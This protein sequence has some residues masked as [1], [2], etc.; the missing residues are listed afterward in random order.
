MFFIIT[1][2]N[3][4]ITFSIQIKMDTAETSCHCTEAK[5]HWCFSLCLRR[6]LTKENQNLTGKIRYLASGGPWDQVDPGDHQG[7][8]V[9]PWL[10]FQ[11]ALFSTVFISSLGYPK[12]PR[13]RESH[14]SMRRKYTHKSK[15]TWLP[16]TTTLGSLYDRCAERRAVITPAGKERQV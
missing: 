4:A 14:W 3:A 6:K 12:P 8:I 2:F 11:E 16:S 7:A 9:V 10:C 15:S 5:R 13:C 1:F